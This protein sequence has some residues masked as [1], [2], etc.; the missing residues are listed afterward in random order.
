[1]RQRSTLA[2]E[3][4]H[5]LFED[6]VDSDAGDWSDRSPAQIRADAV[7][8]HLLVPVEGL[9]EFIGTPSPIGPSTLS[10]VV[11]R[12]WYH[13][14]SPRPHC[15]RPGDQGLCG[16]VLPAQAIATLRKTSLEALVQELGEAGV[17][18]A[19]R[20]AARKRMGSLAGA[21]L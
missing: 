14:R 6:W 3:L 19:E 15:A 7:A 2:H 13:P 11:Q 9:R 20:P 5:V 1:M 16:S 4:G 12:F 10:A 8:R 21:C 17:T 18:P